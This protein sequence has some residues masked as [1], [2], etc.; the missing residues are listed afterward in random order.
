[1]F[2]RIFFNCIACDDGSPPFQSFPLCESCKN[3]LIP[4]PALCENC[5]SPF[6][7]SNRCLHPWNSYQLIKSYSAAYLLL[8]DCYRVLKKWKIRRGRLFDR[9]VLK[10]IPSQH[11]VQ[12][13]VVIPIPQNINR[14][15]LLGGSPAEVIASH[16]A[17]ELKIPLVQCLLPPIRTQVRQAEL[18]AENR[19]KN[20]LQFRL[21]PKITQIPQGTTAI[22]VD[23]FMTTGHTLRRAAYSLKSGG[24]GQIHTFC[25]GIRLPFRKETK[26]VPDL[27]E[28]T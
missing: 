15:W 14:S 23:D 2:T 4:C 8:S 16:V 22:L 17:R 24:I 13:Q 9:Q 28:R 20:P 12:A 6:C 11:S 10:Y 27:M 1:M 18:S 5:A 21:S 25:L 3:A 7:H 19:I 26:F